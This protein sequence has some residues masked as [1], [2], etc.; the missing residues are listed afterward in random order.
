MHEVSRDNK[1][2]TWWRDLKMALHHPDYGEALERSIVW[3][4]GCGGRIK[5]WE[6]EWIAVGGK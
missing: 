2:S 5:F 4:V 1:E 3:R 6:D